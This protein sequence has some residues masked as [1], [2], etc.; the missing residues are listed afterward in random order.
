MQVGEPFEALQALTEAIGAA[1]QADAAVL[2][3]LDEE[4]DELVARTV[5][6]VSPALSAELVGSRRKR[7]GD[8]QD[9]NGAVLRLPVRRG[10]ELVGELELRRVRRPFGPEDSLLAQTAAAQVSLVLGAVELD[11]G[12]D[13]LVSRERVLQLAGDALAVAAEGTATADRIAQIAAGAAGASGA[14]LWRLR[15]EGRLELLAAYPSGEH[16]RPPGLE[17]AAGR[18]LA[19]RGSAKLERGVV[20][21]SLGEPPLG[22]L[23][24]LFPSHSD[25]SGEEL[26]LL[27]TFGVRAAHALRSSEVL[28]ERTDELERT[29]ALV[30]VIGQAIAQLSVA[31][32]LETAVA[33]IAE[34]LD[35]DR[36]AVY[37][38]EGRHLQPVADRGLVGP[39]ARV[40][41]RLLALTLGSFRGRGALVIPDASRA[42]MLEPVRGE[43][44]ES[45]IE[46][47][48]AVPLLARDEVIGLLAVYPPRGRPVD[49]NEEALVSALAA[50]LG[51]AVENARLHEEATRLSLELEEALRGERQSA[52]ELRAL[53]EISRSFTHS[54]SLQATLDA[55]TR[56]VVE[57]L[58]VDAA[59]IRLPD[60]RGAVLETRSVHL[61][62][63]L[64]A[65]ALRAILSRPQPADQPS[66]RR[67]LR[68]GDPLVVDRETAA[69]LPGHELLVPFLDK[70]ATCVVVP[71]A[72]PAEVLA[73]LTIVSL[74]PS[75]PI[76]GE[77]TEIAL[78]IARQAALAVDNARLYQQQKGFAD[79]MQRSLLP[80]RPPAIEG[81]ELGAVYESSARV[82]VGGDVYDF[83]PLPD[84][85]LAVLVGDVTGHGVEAAADMAMAKF[86]FRSL[87][88]EHPEP[89]DF[90]ASANEVVTSE[91]AVGK[92]ITLACVVVDVERG[93]VSC[94]SAGHPS[95]RLVRADGTVTEL[96]SQGLPLG[97][98]ADQRYE[99]VRAPFEP[100]STL[101]L[102]TDGVIEERRGSELYGVERL[103]RVLAERHGLTAKELAAEVIADCRAF[104]GGDL[105]DDC[106]IV[107]VKRSP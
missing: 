48:L 13:E 36:V 40:A 88:R 77:A 89:A 20:T 107:V 25:L 81:L 7:E 30:A 17:E 49:E 51:V 61:G 53:Y 4:R 5:W 55:V 80:R 45:G 87:I 33:R 106:A 90:L 105:T 72:T 95:P 44:A 15:G 64:V 62:E 76:A 79:T 28:I 66:V 60:P 69:A 102:Y 9:G 24:L 100:S 11:E 1:V 78:S 73:T 19:S 14:F 12:A 71:V 97:V 67:M 2:R 42:R 91:I 57:T 29:R 52:R 38:I 75:R 96:A 6:G 43:V 94:A 34:L 86:V 85:R 56:T 8:R 101:V 46:A 59:A 21:L 32:T 47:V 92:F 98:E 39:H 93:E 41:D 10:D 31:H 54:L 70:G 63:P 104:G 74:D 37:L 84:R 27:S 68:S 82:D 83:L 22:A 3:F 65:D 58:G 16:S 103:D 50:Q 26:S 23:Q 99:E 18:A 35:V